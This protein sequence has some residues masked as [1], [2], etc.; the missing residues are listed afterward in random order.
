MLDL[1]EI[2][3]LIS[4]ATALIVQ[5]KTLMSE[6]SKLRLKLEECAR[7]LDSLQVE[8]D[9]FVRASTITGNVADEITDR[10]LGR[11]T[12]VINKAL[13]TLF[14]N[15]GRKIEI[16]QV[17]YRETYPHFIVELTTSDGRKRT[18]KQSGT[19]LGQVISFLFLVCLIDAR[20]GRKIMVIDEVLNGLHPTALLIV[21]DLLIALSNRFQFVVIEYG[22]DVGKQYEISKYG[23]VANVEEYIGAYYKD[24]ALKEDKDS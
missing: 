6:K 23:P 10:T 24:L 8:L 1:V 20:H 17:M 18:F 14:P 2:D 21:R 9:T 4:D 15:D 22:L 19:G 7:E 3:G 16:K 5:Q 12:G 13:G 11:I